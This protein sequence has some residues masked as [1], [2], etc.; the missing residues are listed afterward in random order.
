MRVSPQSFETGSPAESVHELNRRK[1]PHGPVTNYVQEEK[2]SSPKRAETFLA[3]NGMLGSLDDQVIRHVPE[4][5]HGLDV[6]LV[7]Q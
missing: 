6:Q 5:I 2:V 4:K 3:E 7:E 1:I